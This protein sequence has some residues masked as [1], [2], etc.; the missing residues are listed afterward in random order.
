MTSSSN[1]AAAV[2]P[3]SDEDWNIA[4]V[5]WT[6]VFLAK[7]LAA[8]EIPVF[9]CDWRLK[10]DGKISK[11]PLVKWR[12]AS[13]TDEPT[14]RAWWKQYPQA[15]VGID[16]GKAGLV[17]VDADRHGGPDGVAALAA[18]ESN[19]D[20]EPFERHPITITHG[21]GQHHIFKNLDGEP[22]GNAE[23]ALK[24]NGINMRGDGGYVIAVGSMI[25]DHEPLPGE[26]TADHDAPGLIESFKAGNI[27]VIPDWFVDIIRTPKVKPDD[28]SPASE[29][30]RTYDKSDAG[31]RERAFAQ[32][33]LDGCARELADCMEG[34]RNELLNKLS[35][36]VHRMVARGWLDSAEVE[37]RLYDAAATC[38]LLKSDGH[39][40]VRATIA[41]GRKAGLANPHPDLE[42]REYVDP[43]TGECF[44]DDSNNLPVGFI[45][46]DDSELEEPDDL[47]KGLVPNADVVFIGGQSQ[48]GKT[49]VAILL[50]Y[51]IASGA[52]FFGRRVKERLGVA[53]LAAEGGGASY[54]RRLRVTRMRMSVDG[55]EKFPVTYLGD[56]PDLSDS[57]E[58]KKLVPRLKQLDRYYRETYGVRLGVVIIDTVA[59]AFDLDDEDDNSEAAKTIKKMKAIGQQVGALMVPIHHYGKAP[60]TGLRGASGWK[61]GCDAI[62]SVLAD[63]D[64]LTGVAKNRELALAKIR[65]GAAGPVAPFDLCF[66]VLGT[67]SDGDVFGSMYVEPRLDKASLIAATVPVARESEYLTV[68]RQSFTDC[69]CI[70]FKVR[71]TGPEVRAVRL[72]DVRAEFAKR[73][74]TG[75]SDDTERKAAVRKAFSRAKKYAHTAFSF[76]ARDDAEWVWQA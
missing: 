69:A 49:F 52:P 17:V 58:I 20:H 32:A 73:W 47:I 75:E 68:F 5:H 16:L 50:A 36:R 27:P 21:N 35:Y 37:H 63:I 57:K 40:Q 76:E 30:R 8:A 43:D 60:T 67:D 70:P 61:A 44:E 6:N 45:E 19:P 1:T 3:F 48:A 4:V 56:V 41:S 23:G 18:L 9:P 66:A 54:R 13:T 38:G 55:D 59:A 53:I 65:D 25:G 29:E 10:P 74:A 14:I 33:A 15:L 71:G 22:L 2:K 28:A 11:A 72:A 62:L 12:D 64:Q 7:R 31:A 46:D 26:W 39:R 42:D 34:S 24:G 51:C